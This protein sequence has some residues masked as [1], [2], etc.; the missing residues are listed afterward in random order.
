MSTLHR[1]VAELGLAGAALAGCLLSWLQARSVVA[2]APIADGQPVT[3]S[4]VYDPALLVLSLM[5][6]ALAGVL[7]VVGT[8]RL[9]HGTQSR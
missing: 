8:A 7:A 1:A 5:L 3:M 4:A 6:A 9:R 2:V